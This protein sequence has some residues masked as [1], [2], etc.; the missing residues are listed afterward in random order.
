[1]YIEI[2]ST[3]VTTRM[4]AVQAN[5]IHKDISDNKVSYGT[6]LSIFI[7]I[8]NLKLSFKIAEIFFLEYSGSIFSSQKF[9]FH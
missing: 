7:L 5:N 1:M 9:Q 6:H 2:G 3:K 4:Y 8:E